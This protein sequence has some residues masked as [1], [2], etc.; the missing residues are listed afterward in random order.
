[1]HHTVLPIYDPQSAIFTD[2]YDLA[3]A[4]YHPPKEDSSTWID[5]H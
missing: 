4:S 5:S 2:P 1:V 3:W